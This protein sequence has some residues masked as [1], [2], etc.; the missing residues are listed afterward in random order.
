MRFVDLLTHMSGLTYGLQNRNNIDAAYR[1]NNFDFA[2]N[3][4]DSDG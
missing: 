1:E 2:R 4:L 3:H